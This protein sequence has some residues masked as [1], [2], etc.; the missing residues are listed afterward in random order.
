MGSNPNHVTMIIVSD[1]LNKVKM[2]KIVTMLASI[3][4]VETGKIKTEGKT[5]KVVVVEVNLDHM[6]NFLYYHKSVIGF[7]NFDVKV[8][9]SGASVTVIVTEV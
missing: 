7:P 5:S 8:K 6:E 9:R 4:S 2:Q 1:I 3:F